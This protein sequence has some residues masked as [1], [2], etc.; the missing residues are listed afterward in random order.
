MK[1]LYSTDLHG[2]TD[3]YD[4]ILSFALEEK[5]NLIHLGSDLL[6]KGS[7]LIK[8]QKDFIKHFL[9]DFYQRALKNNIQLLAF[10]G[11][12][13]IYTN[14]KYFNEYGTLLDE[15]PVEIQS[16]KF[17]AYPYVCDYPFGLKTACKLDSRNWDRPFCHRP[18]EVSSKGFEDINEPDK[19][20]AEKTTIEEDL[21]KLTVL[22][23]NEIWAFHMPPSSVD[24][25]VCG[26]MLSPGRFVNLKRVGSSSV[27]KWVER[28]QP[29]LVMCGHI[30]ESFDVT[31]TWRTTIGKTLVIQPGQMFKTRF[32]LIEIEEQNLQTTLIEL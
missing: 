23:D 13:D 14:K 9:K 10:F 31:G 15:W 20:F 6:P 32:V 5:I 3:K 11:N 19:Y 27:L 12:D 1:F 8:T 18:V 22:S 29:L 26:T 30:H 24:L 2:H 7:N 21:K 4:A 16:F 28:E 25:D 17:K